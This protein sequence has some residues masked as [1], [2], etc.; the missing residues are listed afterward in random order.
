MCTH[1]RLERDDEMLGIGVVETDKKIEAQREGEKARR[2]E[3]RLIPYA[4]SNSCA[5]IFV[6]FVEVCP[7]K[8]YMQRNHCIMGV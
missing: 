8:N 6:F 5:V 2:I 4:V 1:E 3:E 7:I